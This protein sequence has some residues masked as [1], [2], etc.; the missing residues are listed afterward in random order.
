MMMVVELPTSPAIRRRVPPTPVL[1]S[2][3]VR[4]VRL[5]RVVRVTLIGNV[6]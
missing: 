2:T 1:M 5:G 3:P 6:R 4:P